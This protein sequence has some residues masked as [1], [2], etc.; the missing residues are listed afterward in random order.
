MLQFEVEGLLAE[1]ASKAAF[2]H[3]EGRE[4]SAGAGMPTSEVAVPE[5]A[6]ATVTAAAA[7]AAEGRFG[8]RTG[9]QVAI[10]VND[11]LRKHHAVVSSPHAGSP[12]DLRRETWKQRTWSQAS[13]R[14]RRRCQALDG[15]GDSWE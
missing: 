1:Q 6:V 4:R 8:S 14:Q 2:Y 12:Q 3:A 15:Y 7:D 11:G 9:G 5:D 10:A 13:Q